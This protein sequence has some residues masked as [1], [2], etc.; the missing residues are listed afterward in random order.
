[1]PVVVQC[2]NCSKILELDDGFRGGVCRCSDCGSLLQV[3]KGSSGGAPPRARPAAP[4]ARPTEPPRPAAPTADV[5][6]SRG[7]LDPRS[8]SGVRPAQ[9]DAP[10]GTGA[11]AASPLGSGMVRQG[12]ATRAGPV[13]GMPSAAVHAREAKQNRMLLWAG[14]AGGVILLIL[15]T[16]VAIAYTRTTMDEVGKGKTTSPPGNTALGTGGGGNSEKPTPREPA[17]GFFG[18]PLTGRRIVISI[19]AGGSMSELF[20]YVAQATI[21]ALEQAK[22]DAEFR[23]VL[24]RSPAPAVLPPNGWARKDQLKEIGRQLNEF[25]ASGGH[26]EHQNMTESVKLGGDQ[27][28]FITAKATVAADVADQVLKACRGGQKLDA[29]WISSDTGD[30]PLKIIASSTGGVFVNRSAG[31]IQDYY[32][33]K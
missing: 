11:F 19:D 8:A 14:I 22:P 7:R 12:K 29:V 25:Y 18:V 16:V 20:S 17:V 33:G 28:L 1:M 4:G 3:P 27:T 6:L 13:G 10:A 9:G 2:Y 21:R 15:A 24:W 23:I 5:G 32:R 31:E 30:N 26:D